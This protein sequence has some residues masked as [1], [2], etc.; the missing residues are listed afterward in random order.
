MSS[1]W[2]Q[3]NRADMSE[4]LFKIF[5]ERP[6]GTKGREAFTREAFTMVRCKD[7]AIV[8]RDSASYESYSM[9]HLS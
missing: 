7:F 4:N 8:S 1:Q 5:T 9:N 6:Q 2:C 3:V